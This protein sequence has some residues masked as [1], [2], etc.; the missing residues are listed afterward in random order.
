M[1]ESPA[2]WRQKSTSNKWQQDPGSL[3]SAEKETRPDLRED[4]LFDTPSDLVCPITHELFKDP[5]INA[6]GQVYER[7]AILRCL[8]ERPVDP[9]TRTR[10]E[11]TTLTPVYIVR[12]RA[13]EYR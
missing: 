8:E 4:L 9:I 2:L 1:L 13:I 7:E 5:V 6:C 11:S 3:P 10:L 12:S